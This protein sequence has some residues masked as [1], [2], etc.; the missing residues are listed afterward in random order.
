MTQIYTQNTILITPKSNVLTYTEGET[1][2]LVADISFVWIDT[3]PAQR[4]LVYKW[5]ESNNGTDWTDIPNHISEHTL[6]LN[7][8][9]KTI[10]SSNINDDLLDLTLAEFNLAQD[11]KVSTSLEISNILLAQNN[12]K[13]RCI[14]LLYNNNLN[15]IESAATTEPITLNIKPKNTAHVLP[16]FDIPW[17]PMNPRAVIKNGSLSLD[18]SAKLE[19]FKPNRSICGTQWR[20]IEVGYGT[21]YLSGNITNGNLVGLPK[22]YGPNNQSYPGYMELQSYCN[23]KWVTQESWISLI[24]NPEYAFD[25]Y[26]DPTTVTVDINGQTIVP[27]TKPGSVSSPLIV[28]LGLSQNDIT[29]EIP[30]ISIDGI[31]TSGSVSE[32]FFVGNIPGP[33]SCGTAVYGLKTITIPD[34]IN[35]PATVTITGSSDDDFVVNGNLVKGGCAGAGNFSPYTFVSNSRTFTIAAVDNFGGN[36]GYNVNIVFTNPTS[37]NI[38]SPLKTNEINILTI[39]QISDSAKVAVSSSQSWQNS[40]FS[41][42]KGSRL[43]IQATGLVTW[44]TSGSTS[45]P[46]GV[47]FADSKLDNRFPHEALLGRIGTSAPFLIGSSFK[48]LVEENGILQLATNDTSRFDNQGSFIADIKVANPND[49][50]VRIVQDNLEPYNSDIMDNN[51]AKISLLASVK[52]GDIIDNSNYNKIFNST[53]ITTSTS[54]TKYGGLKAVYNDNGFSVT[55]SDDSLRFD[56]DFTV[57]GWFFF[58]RNNVGYQG[59]VSTY[60]NSDATGWILVIESNNRLYFY[61]SSTGSSGWPVNVS[62]NYTPAINQWIHLAVVRS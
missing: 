15:T 24:G 34:Y 38:I 13:Y 54:N 26:L 55:N 28:N 48:G 11:K 52:D 22:S 16:V 5:Q 60:N 62:T 19:I 45:G 25:M 14:V 61:G 21:T 40:G 2:S 50:G 17:D 18:S 29:N 49:I 53:N 6:S 8:I 58:D 10:F 3:S 59:L 12:Y 39:N 27:A 32:S 46:D 31:S 23:N 42:I 41:I 47:S 36:A 51:F 4:F 1:C 37:S 35:L 43:D 20:I 56:A 33:G 7:N 9:E 44:N 57:E 30:R